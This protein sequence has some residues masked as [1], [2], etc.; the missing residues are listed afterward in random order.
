MGIAAVTL[1]VG[2]HL[3]LSA[4][5]RVPIIHPD[6]LGYLENARFL[7]R[8]GLRSETEYYPGFSLLLVP[9]WWMSKVPALIYRQTLEL[10]AVLGGLSAFLAW[11]LSAHV[12]PALTGRR[13]LAIVSLVAAY[14]PFLLYGDVALAETT[15][16]V[17]F[18]IVVLLAA[19]ALPTRRPGP[20]LAVGVSAGVLTMVHPRGLAVVVAAALM[21]LVVLGLR[22]TSVAP[23]AA[24]A[25]GLGA[26]LA[27]TRGL[28][29]YV[30]GPVATGFA[31]Y[32]P[33]G[34]VSKSLSVHGAASLVAELAGQLFYLSV[35]TFGLV[36]LALLL[37]GTA[38]WRVAR[39]D[40]HP[41]VMTQAF[42]TLSFVGVWALSS[43]FMNLGDRA[44]KLIYGRYNEGVIVPLL[45]MA[46]A[47]VIG[48]GVVE[49]VRHVSAAR[50]RAYASRRWIVAASFTIGV[51]GLFV[52]LSHPPR[53]LRGTLNPV[54]VLALAPVL[55]RMGNRIDPLTLGLIGV[56]AVAVLSTT[57]RR[58]PAV[59][60]LMIAALF[61]ASAIDTERS[62]FVPGT[63]ARA[64]QDDVATAIVAI[65]HATTVDHGCIG[66]DADQSVDYNYYNDRFL[67]P[68]Q[69]FVWFDG[70]RAAAPC[71]TL[72]ISRRP[73]FAAR[74]PAAR[75]ITTEDYQRQSLWAVPRDGD[76]SF[77]VLATGGW[78]APPGPE[79][80]AGVALPPE[81][82][83]GSALAI[84]QDGTLSVASGATISVTMQVAH[85]AGGA[86]WPDA[87][88][89]HSGTALF[90]VQ[91]AARWYP[92]VDPFNHPGD[93]AACPSGFGAPVALACPAPVDLPATLLPGQRALVPLHLR[94]AD[95][96]GHPLAPG[97]YRLQFGLLQQGVGSFSDPVLDVPITVRA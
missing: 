76:P 23:L 26:S 17:V 21:A 52:G 25:V 39:G 75:L 85:R 49:R 91:L 31:A 15:F 7:A 57:S 88:S 96:S 2:V 61:G 60:V 80:V 22:R 5:M 16:V 14:P 8:G 36:P 44:D 71:G 95:S 87:A 13:R 67:L 66:Y 89:L 64:A 46:L 41:R 93:P 51:T 81:A 19:R 9:L 40:R 4:P 79:V 55:V 50:H 54:N 73:D 53:A 38:L 29:S 11:R 97:V 94:A 62:Y 90:A 47:D 86:P 37:G 59:A 24:L 82:R 6:E 12:A 84:V 70:G 35:G 74:H 56:G 30:K 1:L 48:L 68:G 45:I 33:D 92:D 43:L 28:V 72:V 63:R 34:V 42:V 20:W 18:G 65:E 69:R 58:S 27:A 10:E 83:S 77:D 78:L 3:V 32:R